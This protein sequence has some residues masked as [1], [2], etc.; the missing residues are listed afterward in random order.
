MSEHY[1]GILKYPHK[2]P[3]DNIYSNVMNNYKYFGGVI[4]YYLTIK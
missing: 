2:P 4:N 1:F 3:G